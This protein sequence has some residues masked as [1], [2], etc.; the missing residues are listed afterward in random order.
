MDKGESEMP[1]Q[2][3]H[4]VGEVFNSLFETASE[5]VTAAVAASA[6]LSPYWLPLAHD[7]AAQWAPILGCV[8]LLVQIIAK[9]FEITRRDDDDE[10][11][12][13]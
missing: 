5:K 10:G 6:I 12:A 2:P 4:H 11:A 9:L 7:L 8:W 1:I 13:A 3:Q